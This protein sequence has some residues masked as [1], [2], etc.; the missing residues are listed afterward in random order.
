MIVSL[1][2]N[3]VKPK[4]KCA[5]FGTK[6]KSSTTIP[7]NIDEISKQFQRAAELCDRK[8]IHFHHPTSTTWEINRKKSQSTEFLAVKPFEKAVDLV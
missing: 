5:E 6:F 8:F 4:L 1:E 3:W 2:I 7:K